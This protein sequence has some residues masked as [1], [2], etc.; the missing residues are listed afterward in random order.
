M[1]CL[2]ACHPPD[3]RGG[4]RSASR[5]PNL[6]S[7]KV[8]AASWQAFGALSVPITL[9]VRHGGTQP[10]RGRNSPVLISPSSYTSTSRSL[11][12]M[13]KRILRNCK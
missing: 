7:S 2:F 6:Q 10:C 8:A 13:R 5:H 1:K 12:S 11:M 9:H 4:R 3:L